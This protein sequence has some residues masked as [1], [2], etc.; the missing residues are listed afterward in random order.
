MVLRQIL[1]FGPESRRCETRFH[2][3]TATYM[4]LVQK[5][6]TLTLSRDEHL[7]TVESQTPSYC[8]ETNTFTLSRV[9]HPHGVKRLT[10][11]DPT[12]S[13]CRVK[14]SHASG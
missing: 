4:A 10:C 12:P 2:E 6:N 9:K 1:G 8:P 11:R 14:H 5:S 7:H 13:R 3:E